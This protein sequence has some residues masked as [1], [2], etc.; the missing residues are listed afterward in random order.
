MQEIL[1]IIDIY[2]LYTTG[3]YI[4]SFSVIAFINHYSR[5][6]KAKKKI[7]RVIYQERKKV[8]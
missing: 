8:A 6:H 2:L 4:L 1:Y 5:P 7:K 3:F